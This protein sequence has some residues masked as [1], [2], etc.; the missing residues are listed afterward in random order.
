MVIFLDTHWKVINLLRANDIDLLALPAHTSHVAQP[1]DLGLNHFIKL[2]FR[3]EWP[4]SLPELP[5]V[6]PE[7]GRPAKRR[8]KNTE[9]CIVSQFREETVEE[10]QAR[11]SKVAYRRA[12][13]VMALV[14]AL[15][16]ACSRKNIQSAFKQAHL[17]QLKEEPPYTR[18][19]EEE[20]IRE[21]KKLGIPLP[22]E[23]DR[24]KELIT[25]F[26]TS[27]SSIKKIKE[28][29]QP[30]RRSHQRGRPSTASVP[31][32]DS[33]EV[34]RTSS[35]GCKRGRKP[36]TASVPADDGEEE[37]RRNS[38][39]RKRGRP[40]KATIALRETDIATGTEA[41]KGGKH[42]QKSRFKCK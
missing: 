9:S 3:Q 11:V 27:D 6:Q 31:D 37:V 15:E 5:F 30:E 16:K 7:P 35:Q 34:S 22:V 10:V 28:L 41:S 25:G 20:L 14:S 1:L 23:T 8:R 21:A 26:L 2:F 12:K 17:V 18:E 36:P 13:V 29:L 42:K 4:N 32:S 33:E 24:K 40:S 19:K 39:G 38:R